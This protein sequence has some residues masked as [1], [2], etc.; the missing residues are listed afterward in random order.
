V[1]AIPFGASAFITS[2]LTGAL[3]HRVE[4]RVL[5]VFGQLL[6]LAAA[7]L[8]VWATKAADHYWPFAFPAM[9]IGLAGVSI[10][11]VGSS[12]AIMEGARP[13]EQGVVGG[14]MYT[15]YQVGA[16]VGIAITTAVAS[17]TSKTLG[18]NSEPDVTGY[19]SS[20]WS[21]VAMH[22]LVALIVVFFVRK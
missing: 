14:V 16:T 12:I 10:T 13:G 19:Q 6:M 18:P 7:I 4:R 2:W 17:G 1:H 9:V 15:A 11:Y 22:G 3:S 21:L 20:F 5:L 8:F